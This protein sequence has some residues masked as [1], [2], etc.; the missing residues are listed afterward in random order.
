MARTGRVAPN[1]TN[2][3]FPE[4][5]LSVLP[6]GAR[7]GRSEPHRSPSLL[8]ITLFASFCLAPALSAAPGGSSRQAQEH[9]DEGMRL[10]QGGDLKGAEAQLRRAVELDP[11][12]SV[13]L[14][15]LG[16]VLG[17]EQN[18]PESN[19]YLE[20]ALR[21]NPQDLAS[22]RNLASNQFQLGL[23]QPAKAN[24]EKLLKAKPADSTGILLLGMVD[25][26][27]KDY[28]NAVRLL[29]SVP[30]QVR[31]QPKSIAALA[32][33]YY[34]T[35][36]EA[37]AR[38]T[39]KE[40]LSH[41]GSPAGIFLGGQV[42]D[43]ANDYEMA[44]RMFT[45]IKE[46]YPDPAKLDYA[47]ALVQYH[48]NRI[49]ESEDTLTKLLQAGHNTADIYN[50][51]GWCLF[52][53]GKT[54]EAV[55]ALDKAIALDPA[56]EANYL[57]VGMILTEARRY[58]GALVA[59]HRALEVAPDS[60]RAYRLKGLVEN[61]LDRLKDA[62]RSYAQAA[63]LNP[64][65]EQSILGLA[66]AQLNEGKIQ[67][68]EATFDKGIQ[69]LPDDA[70]L[71]QAYGSMLLWLQGAIEPTTEARAVSL[72]RTAIRLDGTQGVA[73]YQLGRLALRRGRTAEAVQE[74]ETAARLDPK[75]PRVHYVLLTAY[76][77]L[78]RTNDAG[79]E[80]AV[81]QNLKA[82]ESK[83]ASLRAPNEN[84]YPIP[85]QK[86]IPAG[87]EQSRRE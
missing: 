73:H 67:E 31:E 56:R 68:A 2:L 62:E 46:T 47:F 75:S 74:L 14:G 27:L 1:A 72:L 22:R 78:G 19:V 3:N 40:L 38:E 77:K 35:G 9:A 49:R 37:K 30:D 66:S 83:S 79:K 50:L 69:R 34:H 28:S 24:L 8:V 43:L 76:R 64:A 44:E 52:K 84:E 82:E 70:L 36:Q 87:I 86:P 25:E 54:K 11:D 15:S 29:A 61:K 13:Y 81:Y 16:A 42:A 4:W 71:Y 65:D 53:Q 12:N 17:M 60:Y 32:R 6:R 23:L 58:E 33:A 39:L 21:I 26:E 20:R 18:L 59:A 10:V 41:P 80:L 51:L 63:E 48:A 57:D 45:A 85:E 7:R 5:G 55:A